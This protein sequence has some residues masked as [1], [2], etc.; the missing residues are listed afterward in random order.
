M[1]LPFRWFLSPTYIYK[2]IKKQGLPSSL[3]ILE[4][5]KKSFNIMINEMTKLNLQINQPDVLIKPNLNKMHWLEF[6]K[7]EYALKQGELVAREKI[8]EINAFPVVERRQLEL[9]VGLV[10]LKFLQSLWFW[11]TGKK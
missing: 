7:V 9:P 11:L 6:D 5:T 4:V 3:K 10:K 2:L 8:D 1:P